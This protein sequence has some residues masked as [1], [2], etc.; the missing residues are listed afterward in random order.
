MIGLALD[1]CTDTMEARRWEMNDNFK[2]LKENTANLE[3][4]IYQY[5][6]LF[7]SYSPIHSVILSFSLSLYIPDMFTPQAL[8]TIS[9]TWFILLLDIHM[10]IA[11]ITFK[12]FLKCHHFNKVYLDH[13]IWNCSLLTPD[14]TSPNYFSLYIIICWH[15][16]CFFGG[17]V[18]FDININW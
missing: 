7:S 13:L 18:A 4:Y 16:I 9:F 1:F 15:I 2:W 10:V 17:V 11:L 12:T 3:F 8:C 14:P 5:Y 6:D